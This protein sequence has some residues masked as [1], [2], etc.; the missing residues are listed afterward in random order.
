MTTL[1]TTNLGRGLCLGGAGLGAIGLI[2]WLTGADPLATIVPGQPPMMPNGALAL[3]LL[4]LAAALLYAKHPGR[5][6]RW[7]S[8]LAAVIVLAIGLVTIA[9]YAFDLPFSI[10]QLLIRTE[11]G[12]YPG[13]PS[14]PTALDLA[15]LATAILLIGWHPAT[16]TR[17][18]EWLS[19]CAGLVAFTALMAQA[20][21]AGEVYE[22]IN[23]PVVGVAVPTALSLLMISL[24]V[25]L[26]RP[27]SGI[28]GLATSS[29]LGG[30]LFRR[31][32]AVAILV[33]VLFG[34]AATWILT[35]PSVNE[36]SVLLA[37]VVMSSL[38]SLLLLTATSEHLNRALDALEQ[39]RAQT[40]DVIELASDGIFIADLEGRYIDVNDA[41]CRMLG[42]SREEVL[43]K[44]IMDF[45]PPEDEARL[46][47]DREQFLQGGSSVGEWKLLT[48]DQTYLTVEVG[49][50]ILPDGR[51]LAFVRDISE[52][53]R[54]EDKV[55]L[56]EAKFSGIVSISADAIV[57][58]DENQRITLFNEGAEKIFGWSSPEV[59]GA[60]LDILI[61]ER[62]R[63]NHARDVDTF[64]AGAG[65]A[66]R[67]GA[68]GAAIFGVR[69]NGQEFPADAAISGMVVGGRRILTV[70]LRDITELKEAEAAAKRATQARDDILGIVAHDLRN[71]L[72]AIASLAHVLRAKGPE[73]QVGDEIAVAA[74]RMNR[75]IGDL[76]DVTRMEAG[77]LSLKQERLP[78]AEIITDAL[79]GQTPLASSASLEL[80]LETAPE[81]PD[82]S[83]DRDRILQVFENLIG[84][85]IKFTKPGGRITLGAT[86][87]PGEVMFSVSDT[88]CGIAST[89]LPHVF[90]RFWQAPGTE[91]RGM[92]FGLAIVKG[93]VEAHG[94]RVWVQSAPGQGS[95]FFFTIPTAAAQTAASHAAQ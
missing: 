35:L 73:A 60:P 9:E 86:T 92:G 38:V 1:R 52:R 83:A 4:G 79:E 57:S 65:A 62:F 85:A 34:V 87:R 20:F 11:A 50:K 23:Q 19:L 12:P 42:Y 8:V 39:T 14:P 31:L 67:M 64:A 88:G 40:R 41:G 37:L 2:R 16:R 6:T 89:H 69:K 21:G 91:R 48:K 15:L 17:P 27:D 43:G 70:A 95:T 59:M 81:L 82:I 71:P 90:D 22:V 93:I 33:P 80:R 24:G 75:L 66:R 55:R 13:R 63:A 7:L 5:A 10:D 30:M 25:L 61:P 78:A 54:A 18:S 44:S 76:L 32:A 58:I 77:H 29:G 56:S 68:R 51:W 3:L 46:R 45:I 26:E 49:A 94:G 28:M 74:N 47:S 53:K 84:N 72:A 36:V